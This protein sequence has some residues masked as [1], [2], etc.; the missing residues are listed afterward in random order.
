[1]YQYVSRNDDNQVD[2]QQIVRQFSF[3]KTF[4]RNNYKIIS[5]PVLL[6][7]NFN[8][9]ERLSELRE[10]IENGIRSIFKND[11]T[12]NRCR[13]KDSVDEYCK[14]SSPKN[15]YEELI[16]NIESISVQFFDDFPKNSDFNTLGAY[17]NTFENC[18]T[19]FRHVFLSVDGDYIK[20]RRIDGV[21][22]Y[23]AIIHNT[24][25]KCME[26]V[27]YSHDM[28]YAITEQLNNGLSMFLEN[29]EVNINFI[30]IMLKFIREV[31]MYKQEFEPDFIEVI[32]KFFEDLNKLS[33][34]EFIASCED[35]LSKKDDL[36]KFG[37]DKST[38][39]EA[40]SIYIEKILVD[41]VFNDEFINMVKESDTKNL[42]RLCNIFSI[43]DKFSIFSSHLI[44]FFADKCNSI[45]LSDKETWNDEVHSFVKNADSLILS[46]W[47]ADS[48]HSKL[49][50]TSFNEEIK[51]CFASRSKEFIPVF[52]KALIKSEDL[53]EEHKKIIRLL[54]KSLF[55]SFY[56]NKLKQYLL[57][58]KFEV[59]KEFR[60]TKFLET[61]W[62]YDETLRLKS[63]VNDYELSI[64][65]N[66]YLDSKSYFCL[67]LE[68]R[69]WSTANV[70]S[71]VFPDK[72][73][74]KNDLL[75]EIF[76][77]EFP[78]RRLHFISSLAMARLKYLDTYCTMT[79]DQAIIILSIQ[80]SPKTID[81]ISRET[82]MD[83]FIITQNLQVL[84]NSEYKIVVKNDVNEEWSI[85]NTI[86]F[87]GKRK[88]KFPKLTANHETERVQ[89][90]HDKKI[91]YENRL[92]CAI[93]SAVKKSKSLSLKDLQTAVSENV[94]F[95]LNDNEFFLKVLKGLI[96]KQYIQRTATDNYVYVT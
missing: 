68:K 26:K 10:K 86:S 95:L 74:E 17:I 80:K 7:N 51:K 45:F 78:E 96:E 37:V 77:K 46:L 11:Q 44:K 38:L 41:S 31:K 19:V 92:K 9:T 49:V 58:D 15:L 60:L 16:P 85:N 59:I 63:F 55:E 36:L 82:K 35:Y 50:T 6:E 84:K 18:V 87:E 56:S 72:V 69:F 27:E 57:E 47:D 23:S 89:S 91:Y 76:S 13:L 24:I 53:L 62:D 90:D 32:S 70:S 39:R 52:V 75:K 30:T 34:L 94:D 67:I 79:G 22:S 12:L 65:L 25:N 5:I 64:K 3:I 20:V 1:M 28:I 83:P 73:A 2:N 14:I 88:I 29:K 66:H 33:L 54:N 42:S 21:D 93:L 40:H 61:I 48:E 81:S 43:D 71:L 4:T 8:E